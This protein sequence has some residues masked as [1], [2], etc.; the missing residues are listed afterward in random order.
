MIFIERLLRLET[1][2]LK[3]FIKAQFDRKIKRDGSK[4]SENRL[5]TN[6]S[7]QPWQKV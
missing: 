1:N 6:A 2:A 5:L 3:I 4:P 7:K